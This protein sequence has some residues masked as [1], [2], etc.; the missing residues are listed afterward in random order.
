[1]R[2][3]NKIINEFLA[4]YYKKTKEEVY[5]PKNLEDMKEKDA[6]VFRGK[7][8]KKLLSL[9]YEKVYGI[10][11]FSKFILGDMTYAGYPEPIRFNNLWLQ[12]AKV[13]TTGDH[14]SVLC[15]RQHGKTTYWSVIQTVYRGSM[16]ENYNILVESASSEQA[17]SILGFVTNIIVNN[18]YLNSK[19]SA[20][21]KWSTTDLTYNGGIIRARG[22]GSEV[23]GGTYDYIVCDDILRSDNKLSDNDIEHFIDEELEPMLLVRKG[24][25]ILVGTPKSYTD[26]FATIEERTKAADGWK[27][28]KYKAILNDEKKTLLCP[29]RF[30]Y[31]QLMARKRVM[32]TRK[33]DKEFMCQV[34]S[35]GSS[36]FNEEIRKK[37]MERGTIL[38]LSPIPRVEDEV[39]W[40]Y[41]MGIDV[42]RAG[43]AS[44]D[45][46]VVTVIAYNEKTQEKKLCWY[47]REK[48]LKISEQTKIIAE[49]ARNYRYPHILVEKNNIGQDMID[50]LIDNHNLSVEAFTTT[51]T[52]KEDLIRFLIV[53]FEN[54]KLTLP[55]GDERSKEMVNV[56]NNEL[57]RFVVE[58]TR[59][60]NEIM[61]GSGSSH[62]DM[63]MSLALA[64]KNTQGKYSPFA[65]TGDTKHKT[66][67][68]EEFLKTNDDAYW[69]TL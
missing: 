38:I 61:K 11:W 19:R 33:F 43:T 22:V 1:M 49:I 59:A 65:V 52:T 67:K 21:G 48:G 10:V 69:M 3:Y 26:I 12:W 41:Y 37:A 45:F 56:L 23:R 35:S 44:A 24:Q 31:E 64:I 50:E 36:L 39:D 25:I 7:A 51:N 27:M 66:T 5:N 30:T 60:G 16:F 2:T 9:C 4:Y 58:I 8:W 47:W 28:V 18:E 32:G 20:T 14:I 17:E 6:N 40:S 57:G 13:M 34:Y 63:V 15:P 46:T 55:V 68:L 29:D 54:E 42:A 53:Q 62:D